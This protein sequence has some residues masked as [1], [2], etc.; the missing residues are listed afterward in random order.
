MM[1]LI[2]FIN[3]IAGLQWDTITI[4]RSAISFGK[5]KIAHQ[6]FSQVSPKKFKDLR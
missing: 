2:E 1:V 5:V 6:F 3:V 4:Y